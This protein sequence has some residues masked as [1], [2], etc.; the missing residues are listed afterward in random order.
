MVGL[1]PILPAPSVPRATAQLGAALGK[2]FA[3]FLATAG[4]TDEPV[5]DARLAHRAP[6]AA[7]A[8]CSACCRRSQL[9]RVLREVLDED[10]FLSPHGLRAL[11]RRHRDEPFSIDRS[12]A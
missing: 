9:E 5:R 11:S 4:V 2:H 10:A 3:R 8:S 12:A 7:S 6:R 1:L